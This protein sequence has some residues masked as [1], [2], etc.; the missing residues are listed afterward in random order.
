[1]HQRSD[2]SQVAEDDF[3]SISVTSVD[4][5]VHDPDT[6]FVVEDIHCE[7][8]DPADGVRKYLVEWS[9]FPLDECTWEPESGISSILKRTWEERKLT[10]DP[11]VAEAF[12]QKYQE[13]FNRV[14]DKRREMHRRRNA[15]RRRLG[16]EETRFCFR[17]HIYPDSED[18]T[19]LVDDVNND[20]YSESGA[21]ADTDSEEAEED[22]TVDH[23]ARNIV[24]AR[25]PS[26]P[27]KTQKSTNQI[28]TLD[29]SATQAKSSARKD[30]NPSHLKSSPTTSTSTP[31]VAPK[32]RSS[33]TASSRQHDQPSTTGYQGSARRASTGATQARS[34]PRS[35][36]V[37][38][39]ASAKIPTTTSTLAQKGLTAKKSGKAPIAATNIFTSGKKRQPRQNLASAM[40]DISKDP[41]FF[42]LHRFRRKAELRSR[43][44][45]DQAPDVSKVAGQLF[46]IGQIPPPR[47]PSVQ[48]NKPSGDADGTSFDLTDEAW[49]RTNSMPSA[50]IRRSSTSASEPKSALSKRS[51]FDFDSDRSKKKAKTVRFT[52][53]DGDP[54]VSEPL[55]FDEVPGP[56]SRIRSP[57]PPPGSPS[58]PA[59]PKTKLSLATYHS[60]ISQNVDKKIVLAT[61]NRSLDVTFHDIPKDTSRETDRHWLPEFC[62][63][64]CL[65]FKHTVLAESLIAQ[66]SQLRGQD[67][68]S[69]RAHDILCSG[70]ITSVS[71]H[72][73]E[74]LAEHLRVG[75]SGLFMTHENYNIVIYPTRCDGF[76]MDALGLESSNAPDVSLRH[77]FFR[78]SHN[79][80]RLLRPLSAMPDQLADAAVGK[81]Q[82]AVFRSLLGMRYGKLVAGPSEQKEHHFFLA[83]PETAVDWYRSISCWL[84]VCNSHCK[85]Y[86]SFDPGSWSAFLEKSNKQCGVVVIHETAVDFVRR[87]P[88]VAEILQ[89]DNNYSFWRFSATM[90]LQH[91]QSSEGPTIRLT[92]DVF[93]RLFPMGKAI[94]VTP[95]FI[96]TEPQKSLQLFEWF[97]GN[98]TM[99]SSN[100]LVTAYNIV[101]FL[102]D[103]A[104]EANQ[105]QT[106]LKRQRWKY[107]NELEAA[108]QRHAAALSDQD[109]IARGKAWAMA[110][111]WLSV[112]ME[113]NGVFSEDNHVIYADRSIDP[114]DEQSLVNW[115]GWWS[116]EKVDHYRKFYVLGS[117]PAVKQTRQNGIEQPSRACRS[118]TIPNYDRSVVNDP[119]EATR[120]ALKKVNGPTDGAPAID[121]GKPIVQVPT[122][123]FQSQK[124]GNS[125]HQIRHF[126]RDK[127][128][129]GPV[130]IYGIPVSWLDVDMAVH[131]GD[132]T[133][134]FATLKSWFTWPFPWLGDSHQSFS[135]YVAFFYTIEEEWV[136]SK[137]PKGLKPKR[138]PWLVIYRPWEPHKKYD[139]F[140]HG[141]AELIFWDIRAGNQ[142]ETNHSL[143][144]SDLN[145]MQREVV[146]YVQAHGAEKNPGSRVDK[147]WLGGFQSQQQQLSSTL[148]ADKTAEFLESLSTMTLLRWKLPSSDVFMRQSGWRE[149][150]L[151]QDPSGPRV[152]LSDMKPL[153]G[154]GAKDTN[155]C[156]DN[157][158]SR[159]IFHPP[160]GSAAIGP[161]GSSKCTNYLFEQARLERLRDSRATS[162]IYTFTP[163][164]DWYADLVAEG[165]Q[166]EHVFVDRWEKVFEQLKI[167]QKG[168]RQ[169]G[170]T[171]RMSSVSSNHSGSPM[172]MSPV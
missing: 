124:L 32:A 105:L 123:S 145:W 27:A 126:L 99:Y 95:S 102:R 54:F 72:S 140:K 58:P 41:K 36:S 71:G 22:G 115:F 143:Q 89:T 136:P 59:E 157:E 9:N 81:G 114:N 1:M 141:R 84:F 40:V 118:V 49:D 2:L 86:T 94:L 167:G 47:Q 138:H 35:T 68:N 38:E 44:H 116:L 108:D 61:A 134:H 110:E 29:P 20:L 76:Q 133:T 109:L 67:P 85:I 101:D 15:K 63:A 137:F 117:S 33:L 42:T 165:R 131:F 55:G 104:S 6:E 8:I 10:Q 122:V 14:L 170:A 158:D 119:N 88:G 30:K 106:K 148:P 65:H 53:K 113:R 80:S 83:F 121:D 153:T 103:L 70:K 21:A 154:D 96:V 26:P 98:Q 139:K 74:V 78:S 159:I 11:C 57:P 168:S 100:K 46:S 64:G 50:I 51:S 125:E 172:D 18:D 132:P 147:V 150:S 142:L 111:D 127:D 16:L 166:Y 107:M 7:R 69:R 17:G 149:V 52:G 151:I 24:R 152:G 129:P 91:G 92:P 79:I 60:R 161:P 155:N 97:F 90:G 19:E 5:D 12:E 169:A 73:L 163:T 164:M 31:V 62:N 13:A 93:S 162:M 135:T 87:F 146:K 56:T 23:K 28:S 160:R 128:R 66:L 37:S 3:D 45:D 34:P 112:S 144:L 171:S 75:H 4:D 39:N 43:E 25:R 130:R 82:K 156:N 120:I 77:F 48:K